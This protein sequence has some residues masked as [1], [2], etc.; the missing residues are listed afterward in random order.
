M[1]SASTAR[2]LALARP[3]RARHAPRLR[4]AKGVPGKPTL[5]ESFAARDASIPGALGLHVPFIECSLRC[6]RSA[7]SK[8]YP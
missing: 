1:S 6:T 3:R 7:I 2:L 5:R 8:P 4:D